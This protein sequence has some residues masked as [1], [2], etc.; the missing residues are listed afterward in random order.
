MT[1]DEIIAA[2][3][4]YRYERATIGGMAGLKGVHRD[5]GV[6]WWCVYCDSSH[7]AAPG[8]W[9]YEQIRA[10]ATSL[11][12]SEGY[13]DRGHYLTKPTNKGEPAP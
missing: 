1:A 6:E 12:G 9:G 4:E 13:V 8:P 5:T 2:N 3:P 11:A 7:V 10:A